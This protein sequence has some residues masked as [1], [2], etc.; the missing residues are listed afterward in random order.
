LLQSLYLRQPDEI[1]ELAERRQA[2]KGGDRRAAAFRV[3][4]RA[5]ILAVAASSV[6]MG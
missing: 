5:R 2:G 3:S 6:P 1:G 4:R